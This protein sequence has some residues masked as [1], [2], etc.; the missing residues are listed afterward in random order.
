MQWRSCVS[1]QPINIFFKRKERWR[2][3]EK[4]EEEK[5]NEGIEKEKDDWLRG[6][7]RQIFCIKHIDAHRKRPSETKGKRYPCWGGV[8]LH[9]QVSAKAGSG[10]NGFKHASAFESKCRGVCPIGKKVPHLLISNICKSFECHTAC[11]YQLA[12][13]PQA[14]GPCLPCFSKGGCP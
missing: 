9:T 7:M 14:Q 11:H 1:R 3:A 6:K 12:W 4:N 10:K 2:E 13:A 8:P 5:E